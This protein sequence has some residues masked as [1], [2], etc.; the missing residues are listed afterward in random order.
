MLCRRSLGFL[1]L[2]LIAISASSQWR[3]PFGRARSPSVV[4]AVS[5]DGSRV[6]VARSS[7]GRAKRYGRVE[8][9]DTKTGELQ[10]T[11]AGFDGPIWSLTFA[12]DGRSL[13]TVST[14]YRTAKIQTSIY[15]RPGDWFAELKWWDARTGGFIKKVSLAKEQISSVEAAWSSRGDLFALIERYVKF[16][17][18]RVALTGIVNEKGAMPDFQMVEDT[19]LKLLDAQTVERKLKL[20]DGGKSFYGTFW[21]LGGLT[22][23]V[24]SFDEATLAVVINEE[25]HLWNVATGKKLR[26]IKDLDGWPS[27]ITFSPDN[28]Q[29]AIA[30]VKGW[31]PTVES[32]ITIWDLATGKSVNTLKS[33]NDEIASLQFVTRGDALLIGS[34]R[35]EPNLAMGTLKL[36]NLRDNGLKRADLHE[37]KNVSFVKLIHDH[38]AMVVQSESVV[39][40][41][42]G[43]TWRVVHSFEASADDKAEAM[44]RS[45][46]LLTAKRA[47]A[48][49][50]SRDGLTVSAEIPGEGIRRWD[51]RTGGL[52]SRIPRAQNSDNA[53]VMFS[54]GGNFVVET[55]A[56]G[57]RLRDLE[58]GTTKQIPLETDESIAS[59]AVSADNR[60]LIT[61]DEAGVVQCWDTQTGAS[62]RTF[63]VGQQVTALAIDASGQQL[64]IARADRSIVLWNLK[65]GV[66]KS[67]LRKHTDVINA[68]AFS[69]DGAT[70]A[71]GGDDRTVILW[72]TV[73]GKITR[74]L[75]GHDTTVTSLAFSPDGVKLASGS[76]NAA[77]VL[78]NV[79]TGKLDRIL[80]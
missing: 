64:A 16:R 61:A 66:V 33:R 78:W 34:L 46:F 42:D 65:T 5:P 77:V 67:D 58:N 15:E 45:H 75:K 76:G 11:I 68:L 6:A 8:L 2:L 50:F 29:L 13:I 27:A 30:V 36:W 63:Q 18:M 28:R 32:R 62:K 80:R 26:V 38:A 51:S 25:V 52:T 69:A 48:V 35:Y 41:R 70:L 43:R 79:P 9:W 71:S 1:C 74:T 56:E 31:M 7:G 59:F 40:I 53:V 73:T 24:F 4:V 49:A 23:P 21:N 39:E 10:R 72:D 44:R 60:T 37:G 19:E 47:V 22:H 55:T 54:G 14:E 3:S 20:E 57:E 17:E 12:N